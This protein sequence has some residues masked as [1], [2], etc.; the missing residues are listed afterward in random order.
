VPQVV[1]PDLGQQGA[2][3]CLTAE[4]A[5]YL[6]VV[7]RAVPFPLLFELLG[8]LGLEHFDRP[9]IQSDEAPATGSLGFAENHCLAVGDQ[10]APH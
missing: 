1:Q 10:G 7:R 9:R 5:G 2:L 3:H 8:R 6:G 4:A